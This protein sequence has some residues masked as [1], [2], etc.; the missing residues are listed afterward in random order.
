MWKPKAYTYTGTSFAK[1]IGD[2][3]AAILQLWSTIFANKGIYGLKDSW[4]FF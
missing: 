1:T 4:R 3:N 2:Q